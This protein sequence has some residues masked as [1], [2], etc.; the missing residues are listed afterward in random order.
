MEQKSGN[1]TELLKSKNNFLNV[2]VYIY[3]TSL[4]CKFWVMEY[5]LFPKV[6]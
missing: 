6:E 3:M 5:L 4:K 2:S 1:N